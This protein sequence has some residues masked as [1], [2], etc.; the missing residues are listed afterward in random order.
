MSSV[1]RACRNKKLNLFIIH[2]NQ[3]YARNLD[4]IFFNELEL[5]HPMHNLNVRCGT[6][7][8][9]IGRMLIG[10]ERVLMREKPDIVLVQGDTNTAFAGALTA[11]RLHVK[12]GHIEAGLRSYDRN[13]PEELN[14]IIADHCSDLLFAPT[15]QAKDNLLNEG[16][17]RTKI[18]ITGNTI[19][20]AIRQN[21][22]IAVSKSNILGILSIEK[23]EYFVLTLHRQEN[24]DVK[25]R[26]EKILEGMDR[27]ADEFHLPIIYPVH[28][29]AKKMIRT[30]KLK[31]PRGV[32]T[33]SPLGYFDF[34]MLQKN[35]KLIFTD[36]GGVQ[37]EACILQVPCITLR[38][39]TERPETIEIGSNILVGTD[40]QKIQQET[41]RSLRNKMR[42]KNPF[43]D[44]RAGEKIARIISK[45]M[46]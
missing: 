13:M 35:A 44:G 36:S 33:I 41:M 11:S 24:V 46:T 5:P 12:I 2:T 9:E 30:F 8:E 7:A 37:E 32:R 25:D 6:H 17:P 27:L 20:D 18:F 23:K 40:A 31:V 10:I 38:D 4:E 3:H 39:N 1:L 14:R 29:R 43:G 21:L 34:L 28:P 26:L 16:I 19:V 45:I 22:K 42:W 15:Q